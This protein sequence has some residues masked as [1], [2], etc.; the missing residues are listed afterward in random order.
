M[1][2]LTRIA[3]GNPIHAIGRA[4]QVL[5]KVY[6]VNYTTSYTFNLAGEVDTM[7][8]PSG[9]VIK[10]QYDNIGRLSTAKN[11]ASGT[12]YATSVTYNTASQVTGFS[13]ANGV[14]A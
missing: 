3:V 11:N 9:R 8:Y 14:S 7:T 4:T 5:K 1:P 10:Q 2:T 13:Y 12:Q 6:N